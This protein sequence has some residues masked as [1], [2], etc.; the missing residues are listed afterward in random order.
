L[1]HPVYAHFKSVKDQGL[2]A[3][4]IA[5][6]AKRNRKS[7]KQEQQPNEYW[8]VDPDHFGEEMTA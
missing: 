3:Q 6:Y 1:W 2:L 8:E 4:D 5:N 7:K